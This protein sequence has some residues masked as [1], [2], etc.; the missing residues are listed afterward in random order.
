[1]TLLDSIGNTPLMKLS[2]VYVKLEY[3]NPSGSVKDRIAKYIIEKAEKTGKLKNGYTVIEATSGNTGIAFSLVCALKG[4]KMVVVMPRGMS[5]ERSEIINAYGAKIINV[6]EDCFSCA[7][8]KVRE[9]SKQKN[10]YLPKQFENPWN[11][12]DHEKNLGKEIIREVKKVDAFVAGVGTGGTIIGVS[13]ALKKKFPKVKIFALEPDE[14]HLLASSGI[15]KVEDNVSKINVCRHHEIEGIGDGIVS[16]IIK[17]DKDKLDGII[18]VKSKD[19]I[20]KCK[21]LAKL[22]YFVGPSSGANLL[23]ALKLKRKY[24][25]VVTLFPDRGNRYLSEGIFS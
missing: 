25:N 7:I 21:K 1:M 10:T 18:E 15:G 5:K 14:C 11:V 6:K 8:D 20:S 9:M 13:K 17:K 4:Y 3:L 12:E 19:A 24:K 16:D 22:G 2:G 23:G